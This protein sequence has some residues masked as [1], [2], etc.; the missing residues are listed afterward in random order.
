MRSYALQ[1]GEYKL[2][3]WLSHPDT[4]AMLTSDLVRSLTF[5]S[6]LNSENITKD[7]AIENSD[8]WEDVPPPA[9]IPELPTA[10]WGD[11]D[12]K[13]SGGA[14]SSN[15]STPTSNPASNKRVRRL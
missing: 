11:D 2:G 9:D 13:G 12:A 14:G 15:A 3:A 6:S 4:I 5:K 10:D 7:Q 8:I 1:P